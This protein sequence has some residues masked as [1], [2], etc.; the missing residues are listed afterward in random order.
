MGLP[1]EW[2][3]QF[4]LSFTESSYDRIRKRQILRK[5]KNVKVKYFW[6][7]HKIL[8]SLKNFYPKMLRNHM[9][10][11]FLLSFTESSYDRIWKRQILQKPKNVK[12]KY[13]W[14]L[15]ET[16]LSLKNFSPKMLK[17][18]MQY[19]F[20]LS[21]TESRYDRIR[22]RQILRKPKNVKVKYFWTL[23]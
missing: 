12:V 21:F 4:L 3:C 1:S 11:Q 17:N 18:Y 20:V 7:L 2:L 15:H 23:H 16:L 13:F 9:L 19:Q 6:I 10:C 8:F 5:P 22:K 14:T